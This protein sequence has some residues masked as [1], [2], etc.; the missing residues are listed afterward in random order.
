MESASDVAMVHSGLPNVVRDK[1]ED[2]VKTS[3][4]PRAEVKQRSARKREERA[5][6]AKPSESTQAVV[7]PS[8]V[9]L[10]ISAAASGRTSGVNKRR[11]KKHT[12]SKTPASAAVETSSG[13]PLASTKD[14]EPESTRATSPDNVDRVFD[15]AVAVHG[16][17]H[18]R[19][20]RRSKSKKHAKK[21]D[22]KRHSRNTK[23]DV[24]VASATVVTGGELLPA[25]TTDN[26][27]YGGPFKVE[28]S[29]AATTPF[30]KPSLVAAPSQPFYALPPTAD[31]TLTGTDT[32]LLPGGQ[33]HAPRLSTVINGDDVTV[34]LDLTSRDRAAMFWPFG[35]RGKKK[36]Q[37]EQP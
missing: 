23:E 33:R 29:D 16:H 36:R 13:A 25:S 1:V 21:G 10:E 35:R 20:Q 7:G 12:T 26:Y 6:E 34:H 22:G 37:P 24:A 9:A 30:K 4:P 2:A 19:R 31:V 11:S 15:E 14:V 28:G 8:S 32:A 5:A 17:T 27:G 18:H 3:T